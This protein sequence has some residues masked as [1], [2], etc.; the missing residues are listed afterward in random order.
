MNL[1]T[2]RVV[3]HNNAT[4][5]DYKRLKEELKLIGIKDEITGGGNTYRLS[6]G[7]YSCHSNYSSTQLRDFIANKLKNIFA[8]V[9]VTVTEAKEVAWVGLSLI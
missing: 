1:F 4:A 6:P 9:S 8:S 7:E 3:L 2:I 5:Q